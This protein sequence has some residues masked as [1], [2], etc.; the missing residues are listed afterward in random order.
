MSR[1]SDFLAPCGRTV[2]GVDIV[3]IVPAH[4]EHEPD[5]LLSGVVHG[6]ASYRQWCSARE[7][8]RVEDRQS[9]LAPI[10]GEEN[11]TGRIA[12]PPLG[13]TSMATASKRGWS[14]LQR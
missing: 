2:V 1:G 7:A 12:C 4:R 9:C 6:A 13:R 14:F 10:P 8:A 11:G 5:V 3:G